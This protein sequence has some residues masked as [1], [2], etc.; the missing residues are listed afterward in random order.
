MCYLYVKS[1]YDQGFLECKGTFEDYWEEVKADFVRSVEK[2]TLLNNF[3]W[4]VWLF[5]MLPDESVCDDKTWQWGYLKGRIETLVR[6]RKE[7]NL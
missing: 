7:F 4:S 3:Y 5:M 2:L 1:A 6:Q